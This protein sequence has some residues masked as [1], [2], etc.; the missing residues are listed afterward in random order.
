MEYPGIS[1]YGDTRVEAAEE[2]ETALELLEEQLEEDEE[3]VNSEWKNENY[4]DFLS[5]VFEKTKET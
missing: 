3:E 1:A 5:K 4:E 2:M